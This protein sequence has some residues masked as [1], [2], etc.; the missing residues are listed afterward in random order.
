VD[1]ESLC[2]VVSCRSEERCASDRNAPSRPSANPEGARFCAG[3]TRDAQRS[4]GNAQCSGLVVRDSRKFTNGE[5]LVKVGALGLGV[6][7]WMAGAPRRRRCH[8]SGTEHLTLSL[9]LERIAW[10]DCGYADLK[11]WVNKTHTAIRDLQ[12]HLH[13]LHHRSELNSC[14]HTGAC[15][16]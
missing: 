15:S 12:R 11:Y 8:R 2:R 13:L 6:V 7:A 4:R 14:L 1:N 10:H 16:Q 5:R 9:G 3:E